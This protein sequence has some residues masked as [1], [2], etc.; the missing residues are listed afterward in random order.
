MIIVSTKREQIY[1]HQQICS[2]FRSYYRRCSIK[3]GVLRNF[4]KFTGKKL[5]QSLFFIKKETLAQ[6]FLCEVC[7]VFKNTFLT[8][9]LW[10]TASVMM[11][12]NVK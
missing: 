3:N 12:F 1:R 4:A 2:H 8:D 9:F 6:V 5:C 10:T 11:K 7:K